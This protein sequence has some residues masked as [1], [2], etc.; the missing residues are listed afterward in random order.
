MNKE[1][2]LT[3]RIFLSVLV[4]LEFCCLLYWRIFPYAVLNHLFTAFCFCIVFVM[5][6]AVQHYVRIKSQNSY[7]CLF[8]L[9]IPF[10]IPFA[11]LRA[12]GM[13]K[14]DRQMWDR[15]DKS[16]ERQVFDTGKDH[17]FSGKKVLVLVPHED[18]D[19]LL[20]AG[21]LEQY[22]NYGSEVCVV[23]AETGDTGFTKKYKTGKELGRSRA[24]ESISALKAYGIPEDHIIFL[25]FG[26]TYIENKLHL[27]NHTDEPDKVLTSAAGYD[28][29]FATEEHPAY[30][31]GEKITK[32]NLNNDYISIIKD[33]RPDVIFCI[34]Y[35][36][37]PGHRAVSL[38]FESVMGE[39]LKQDE[40]YSPDI[41]KGFAYSTALYGWH[42]YYN[43]ANPG[44]TV[45][46]HDT[47]YMKETNT[48]LWKDRVRF[49]VSVGTLTHY[50]LSSVTAEKLSFY[51]SQKG[52]W[53]PRINGI[54]NSDKVFWERKTDSLLYKADI[55]ASSGN[56]QMLNDFK[57]F[58]CDN[59]NA[60]YTDFSKISG[61][62]IPSA[63]DVD[64]KIKVQL[65]KASN[66]ESICLYDNPCLDDNV[67]NAK[68]IFEDGSVIET[69]RLEP[70]GSAT[71]IPV[72]K[73]NIKSFEIV[74]TETTGARAGIS[75]IEAYSPDKKQ[76]SGFIKLMDEHDDFVYDHFY[77]DS[78]EIRLNLYSYNYD[79][80]LNDGYRIWK[81]NENASVTIADGQLIVKCPKDQ[82]C[83][84]RISSA[85]GLVSDT[86]KVT[87]IHHTETFLAGA[88][89]SYDYLFVA[90]VM[91]IKVLLI[92]IAAAMFILIVPDKEQS[93]DQNKRGR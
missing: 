32:N 55:T 75:E 57:L 38:T 5:V 1:K 14:I 34:D 17:M 59:I 21:V 69:G 53:Q 48:Y 86:V 56:P 27:Y 24:N 66:V 65:G 37:H 58:D 2:H 42:D 25:G 82:E 60:K 87:N 68:I 6:F 89:F 30:R 61:V 4:S 74:L 39:I 78:D 3:Y 72:N 31:D 23:F 85:D 71:R 28:Y 41:Y 91:G 88:I 47:D 36:S 10:F 73:E 92:L 64:K 19:L 11:V 63:D 67:I 90:T 49:P 54:I 81:S 33:Y 84:I 80:T 35:D 52:D 51:D 9:V 26:S 93:T 45:N 15:R 7:L 43:S 44:A 22:I 29:T 20:T 46:P 16:A 40:S 18:D 83:T 50:S 8:L 12:S 76:G 79:T 13:Y 70:N 77:F 62:W